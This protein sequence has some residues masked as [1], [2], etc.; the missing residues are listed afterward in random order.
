MKYIKYLC[1]WAAALIIISCDDFLGDNENPNTPT[2]ASPEVVLP[3][4]LTSTASLTRYFSSTAG[5]VVGIFVNA[6][7]YGGWGDVVYYNYTTSSHAGPWESA[8]DDLNNYQYIIDQTEGDSTQ[9]YANGIAKVM[10]VYDY[11]MLVDF[12]GDVPYSDA[13]SGVDNLMPT[14]DA[15]EDVY[16]DLVLTLNE[17]IDQ[18]QN[19]EFSNSPEGIDIVFNGNMESWAQF[20]N[21]LK[22]RLLIRMS[23]TSLAS[24][25]QEQF[26]GM[27]TVGFITD[28]VVLNPGYGE[29]SGQQNPYWETYVQNASGTAAGS[30]RSSIASEYTYAFYDGTKINDPY[31]GAVVYREFG[32][33]PIGQL[34]DLNNNPT[35]PSSP[36]P[37]WLSNYETHIGVLKGPDAGVALMLASES[38]FL[39]AEA[40]MKGA[41][42]GDDEDAYENGIMASFRYLYEDASGNIGS[43]VDLDDEDV[44]VEFDVEEDVAAYLQENNTNPLVNY[45]LA[46]SNEEKLEAIIT[47]K[48]IALNFLMAQEAWSEFRRTGYPSVANGST[49]PQST[50]ASILST[51]PRADRLPIRFLYPASEFQLNSDNVPP[52]VDQFTTAIFFQGE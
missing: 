35:A 14:Y 27:E 9:A 50:F 8:F 43:N 42:S 17:A 10:R 3:N 20:A 41:L 26:S 45:S 34:G 28:D 32:E 24:F 21:T 48:Y 36:N 2:E 18:F 37:S 29:V 6:G 5:W 52:G 31:R 12:Y 23:E 1:V 38:Y 16:Q 40:Y 44:T 51:S 47:Q 49:N 7:G 11:Q 13:L 39:Q 46:N 30:G 33:T 4:A 22:L 15:Q 19:S 25:A